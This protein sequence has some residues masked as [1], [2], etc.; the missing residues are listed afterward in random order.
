MSI[1]NHFALWFQVLKC[2]LSCS[3]NITT[4][5]W[6]ASQQ[7][8]IPATHGITHPP[9]KRISETIS[10]FISSCYPQAGGNI[11]PVST[12]RQSYPSAGIDDH[13]NKS[14]NSFKGIRFHPGLKALH[15][16]ANF[17]ILN[18]HFL[19]FTTTNK[20]HLLSP[21]PATYVI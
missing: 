12:S 15:V 5:C 11:T 14:L 21:A 4:T 6:Q 19:N 10:T 13:W 7:K 18:A 16:K 2:K 3:D 8:L 9:P 20:K 1:L 17:L